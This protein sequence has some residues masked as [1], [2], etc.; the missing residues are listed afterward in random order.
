MKHRHRGQD[1]SV[2]NGEQDIP[3]VR[4]RLLAG[5]REEQLRDACDRGPQRGLPRGGSLMLVR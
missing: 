5:E 3:K 4:E 1:E 2:A